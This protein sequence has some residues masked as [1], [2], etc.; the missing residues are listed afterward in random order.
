MGSQTEVCNVCCLADKATMLPLC[1]VSMYRCDAVDSCCQSFEYCVSC[2]MNPKNK[3]EEKR[4]SLYRAP[5]NK[6][7]GLWADTFEYCLAVCRT[8]GRSTSHENAYIGTR[9]HCFSKLGKPMVSSILEHLSALPKCISVA[10]SS[11]AASSINSNHHAWIS[12]LLFR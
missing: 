4:K 10:A 7:S 8:H 1:T 6:E 3:P 11:C 12:L 9:H 5:N 2:C